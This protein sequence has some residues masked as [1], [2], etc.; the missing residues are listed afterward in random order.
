MSCVHL[1]SLKLTECHSLPGPADVDVVPG[2][3]AGQHSG[4]ALGDVDV[5][6]RRGDPQVGW[7]SREHTLSPWFGDSLMLSYLKQ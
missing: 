1:A 6:G 3:D 5:G 7:M 2:D 4:V